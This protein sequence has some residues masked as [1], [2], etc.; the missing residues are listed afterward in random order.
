MSFNLKERIREKTREEWLDLG[1]GKFKK[2]RSWIQDNGELSLVAGLIAGMAVV[3]APQV[4]GLLIFFAA[5]ASLIVWYVSMPAG[6][7][8]HRSDDLGEEPKAQPD[9]GSNRL[10]DSGEEDSS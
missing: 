6:G 4:I 2:C 10:V 9:D 7:E 3:L 8:L 1:T 5:V